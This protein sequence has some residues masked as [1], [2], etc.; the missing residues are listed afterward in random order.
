MGRRDREPEA[1][2]GA[3]LRPVRAGRPAGNAEL[4]RRGAVPVHDA[5]LDDAGD[6][7]DRLDARA[8]EREADPAAPG[9]PPTQPKLL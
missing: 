2:L 8:A 5:D 6:L 9:G 4:L 7:F 1:R 3:A